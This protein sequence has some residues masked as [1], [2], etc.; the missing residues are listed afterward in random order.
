M[1]AGSTSEYQIKE[2]LAIW[3]LSNLSLSLIL[4]E[5]PSISLSKIYLGA[6]INR[7]LGL[8]FVLENSRSEKRT[9]LL[10][11][12]SLEAKTIL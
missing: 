9:E 8:K 1:E 5:G 7:A 11:E 10:N 12:I 3:I 6:L 2:S 4:A